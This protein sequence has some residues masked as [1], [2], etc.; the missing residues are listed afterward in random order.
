[1]ANN[2]GK[3]Y[4]KKKQKEAIGM[5]QAFINKIKNGEVDVENSGWWQGGPGNLNLKVTLK[6]KEDSTRNPKF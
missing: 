3:R 4:K 2:V 1:M 6:E 5:L